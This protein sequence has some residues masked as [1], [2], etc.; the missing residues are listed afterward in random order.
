MPRKQNMPRKQAPK[1]RRSI[2]RRS[3]RRRSPHTYR[4]AASD[5][6]HFQL[7]LPQISSDTSGI[8]GGGNCSIYAFYMGLLAHYGDQLRDLTFDNVIETLIESIEQND[9]YKDDGEFS[10]LKKE[11]MEELHRMKQNT[12]NIAQFVDLY[13]DF[14]A[15]LFEIEIRLKDATTG[16]TTHYFKNGE[17]TIYISTN[18]AHF[19]LYLTELP[20]SPRWTREFNT[21][22]TTPRHPLVRDDAIPHLGTVTYE[23]I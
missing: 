9:K 12:L 13:Y 8:R 22:W 21:M 1:S 7:L 16:T 17:R 23:S 14:L 18:N 20:T 11:I 3:I 6:Q 10:F 19:N 4:A 2:R 5:V 15:H